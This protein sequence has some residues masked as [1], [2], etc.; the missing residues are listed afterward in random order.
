[1]AQLARRLVFLHRLAFLRKEQES[2]WP[3]GGRRSPTALL[4]ERK[5]RIVYITLNRPEAF[6]SIDPETWQELGQALV[7]F[8]DDSHLRC[9]IITGAGE[10]AFC[11]GADI[12][13][14]LPFIKEHSGEEQL[15]LGTIMRGLEV[16]KPIIAAINGLALGG[17]L[18]LAL[19]CD[20][21]IASENASF[22]QPEVKLGLIPGWGGTQRLPRAIPVARATEMILTGE[23]IGAQE[24]LRLGLVSKVV[25]LSQLLPAA[26]EWAENL[27]SLGPLAIRA[28]KEAMTRGRDM[29]L[30]GGLRLEQRLFESLLSTEDYEEGTKAFVERRK[31]EFKGR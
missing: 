31:P 22:G 27:C 14:M 16:W 13:Q 24:A 10:R 15:W 18:E 1:M 3:A 20:L 19:A 30:D 25:P 17:G 4:Y 12:Q 26:T 23:P 29:D 21:K 11:T 6:N 5:G 8:R 28:A 7:D 9:A 2:S